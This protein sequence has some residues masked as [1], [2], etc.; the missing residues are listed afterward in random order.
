MPRWEVCCI[1]ETCIE[2]PQVGLFSKQGKSIWQVK[3]FSSI[4]TSTIITQSDGWS[5]NTD[6]PADTDQRVL[7]TEQQRQLI[8]Y[9]GRDGWEP[10]PLN[11][12]IVRGTDW[13]FK[14]QLPDDVT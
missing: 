1:E 2:E 8:A 12:L 9:L 7:R 5:I 14:R 3:L 13:F 10:I 11:N 4:G 6:G